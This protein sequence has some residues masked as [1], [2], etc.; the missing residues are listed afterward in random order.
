MIHNGRVENM[1]T[2]QV[3]NNEFWLFAQKK[4][5]HCHMNE[6]TEGNCWRGMT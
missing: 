1:K 4:Q 5:K 3:S 2:S 6:L